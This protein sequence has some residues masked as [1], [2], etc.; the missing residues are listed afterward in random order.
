MGG[1]L[2]APGGHDLRILS[3]VAKRAVLRGIFFQSEHGSWEPF[4]RH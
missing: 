4:A 2:G 1:F 3:V